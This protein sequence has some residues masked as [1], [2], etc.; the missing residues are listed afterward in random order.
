MHAQVQ[1]LLVYCAQSPHHRSDVYDDESQCAVFAVMHVRLVT[2]F[3]L[4]T[5]SAVQFYT[6]MQR[7]A[8]E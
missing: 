1:C 4:L 8:R 3:S 6:R 7:L 2:C 5:N